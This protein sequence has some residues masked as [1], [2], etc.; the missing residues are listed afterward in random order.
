MPASRSQ[1][2]VRPVSHALISA[3]IFV[4]AQG[5]NRHDRLARDLLEE[6]IEIDTT[7]ASGDTTRAAEA[8]AARLTAAGFPAEDIQVLMPASRK[9]NLVA[10]FRGTGARKP[11]L[12]LAHL[13]V[14]EAR[15]EDWSMDPF[16]L[17]GT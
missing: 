13:D 16:T 6:L 8:M 9:G 7:D 1:S 15:R 10:R 2:R 3:S 11:L 12:L 5:S 4:A 14:V 17:I